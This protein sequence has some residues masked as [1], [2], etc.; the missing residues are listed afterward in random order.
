MAPKACRDE[1][2]CGV[3]ADGETSGVGRVHTAESWTFESCRDDAMMRER[4]NTAKQWREQT[5]TMSS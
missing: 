5:W 4:H 2:G 3:R 1:Y